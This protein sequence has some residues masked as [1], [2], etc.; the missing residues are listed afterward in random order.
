MT[1]TSAILAPIAA[2]LAIA[3]AGSDARA[4]MGLP[5][6][7]PGEAPVVADGV[8]EEVQ[9]VDIAEQLGT[10][11]PLDAKFRDDSGKEVTLRD[12]MRSDRPTMLHL[13]YFRCP[14]L[15]TLVLNEA[16]RTLRD[17]DWTPGEDFQLISISV[18]PDETPELARAKKLGYLAEYDRTGVES[19]IRFLTGPSESIDAICEATGFRYRKQPDGEYAH[20]ATLIMIAPDGRIVRYLYGVKFEPATVRMA[21]LEASEGTIGTPLDRFILWCHQFDPTSKG[22]VLFAF[23]LVQVAGLCTIVLLATGILWMLRRE[24]RVRAAARPTTHS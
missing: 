2:A 4:Q 7:A 24:S 16:F 1:R 6:H 22:Y 12:V 8:P 9:G 15:C 20:P 3:F 18:N 21:L 23:R 10:T 14:M 5:P 11:V 13:G 19:G 17:V